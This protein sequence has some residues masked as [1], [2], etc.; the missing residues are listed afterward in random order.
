MK[1]PLVLLAIA[2]LAA[3][4]A[5]GREE[6]TYPLVARAAPP[7]PFVVDGVTVTLDRAEVAFGPLYLCAT[8]AASSDL[9]PSAQAEL[10]DAAVVDLLAGEDQSLGDIHG[11]SG[12]IR[13][14][15]WDYGLTWFAT[16]TQ[17]DALP[18]A[19]DGHA[20]VFEGTISRGPDS[21]AFALR[22]DAR[23]QFQGS[24]TVQGAPA[25]ADVDDAAVT[26]VVAFDAAAWL[27]GVDFAALLDAG[28]DPAVVP[29]DDPRTNTIVL[30]MTQNQLPTLTWVP[31][32]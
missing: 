6:L 30:A 11:V 25:R 13:S 2:P 7:D 23:P 3:C 16:Q 20:A 15:T 12:A 1:T 29:P 19:P 18:E 28:A 5:T 4:G 31:T 17:V 21:I 22:V 24:R 8:A 27:R 9:C 26:L 32:P 10:A 14:A